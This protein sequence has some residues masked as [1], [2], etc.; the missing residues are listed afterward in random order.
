[1]RCP[2]PLSTRW[3]VR[4]A[5]I[6]ALAAPASS[7]PLDPIAGG[8]TT[9]KESS[10]SIEPEPSRSLLGDR[11][12]QLSGTTLRAA[13]RFGEAAVLGVD[14]GEMLAEE[15]RM[16]EDLKSGRMSPESAAQ[17][18]ARLGDPSDCEEP[19]PEVGLF[20]GL[21]LPEVRGGHPFAVVM[22]PPGSVPQGF[23]ARI[24]AAQGDFRDAS[25]YGGSVVLSQDGTQLMLATQPTFDLPRCAR[26]E[27]FTLELSWSGGSRLFEVTQPVRLEAKGVQ[28]QLRPGQSVDLD[29]CTAGNR[30]PVAWQLDPLGNP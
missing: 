17:Q 21:V 22:N 28:A 24:I 1:M 3:V 29:V 12:A 6:A 2:N 18:R 15:L 14:C 7:A 10:F 8:S 26:T 13:E 5:L 25:L 30:T 11:T 23:Q 4:V 20:D 27:R 16:L 9:T 19:L